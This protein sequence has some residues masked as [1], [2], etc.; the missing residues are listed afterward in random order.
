MTNS[1][2]VIAP[3]K[4]LGMWVFDDARVGLVQEPF[5]GGADTLIDHVTADIP[6]AE[7]GFVMVF[8]RAPFPG[9]QFR[10]EW[11]R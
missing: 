7:R 11:Q 9:S 8:S 10:L 2:N 5:V 4:Y 1:I 6:D 3:Y